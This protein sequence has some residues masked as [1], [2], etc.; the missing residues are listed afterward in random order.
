MAC[1]DLM[2]C[3]VLIDFDLAGFI[4]KAYAISQPAAADCPED[5]AEVQ[6]QQERQQFRQQRHREHRHQ[7][8]KQHRQHRRKAPQGDLQ[9]LESHLTILLDIAEDGDCD[10]VLTAADCDDADAS[11][12]AIDEDA[13]CDGIPT[14]EDCDDT[15]D[16]TPRG[17]TH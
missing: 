2:D 10:G 9:K 15:D 3:I 11:L 5:G 16:K 1:I 14:E 17:Q 8:R 6:H 12:G 7:H 4:W 13:D